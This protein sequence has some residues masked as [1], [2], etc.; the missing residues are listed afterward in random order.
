MSTSSECCSS[1]IVLGH[2]GALQNGML[3][4]LGELVIVVVCVIY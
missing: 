1:T 3:M 4:K 2:V